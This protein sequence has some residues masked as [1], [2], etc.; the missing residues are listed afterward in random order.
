MAASFSTSHIFFS[1]VVFL[2]W[3]CSEVCVSS[4]NSHLKSPASPCLVLKS[5]GLMRKRCMTSALYLFLG[6]LWILSHVMHLGVLALLEDSWTV[7]VVVWCFQTNTYIAGVWHCFHSGFLKGYK[8]HPYCGDAPAFRHRWGIQT[9]V[10]SPC[11]P[12]S[13]SIP[14]NLSSLCFQQY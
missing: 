4:I 1:P 13:E 11:L 7:T 8:E 6:S 5:N 12:L 9:S 2:V 10:V 14:S 3:S